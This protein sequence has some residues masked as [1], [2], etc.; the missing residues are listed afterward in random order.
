MPAP[1]LSELED[2]LADFIA[3]LDEL[4]NDPEPGSGWWFERKYSGLEAVCRRLGMPDGVEVQAFAE[5]ALNNL[6]EAA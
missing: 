1:D 5:E 6:K 2:A 4:E 3:A